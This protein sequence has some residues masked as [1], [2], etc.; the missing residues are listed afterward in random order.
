MPAS[1]APWDR[2]GCRDRADAVP[3]GRQSQ[4]HWKTSA[5][6]F[7]GGPL[8]NLQPRARPEMRQEA[9]HVP[10]ADG[11]TPLRRCIIL[12]RNMKEDRRPAAAFAHAHIPIHHHTDIVKS[13]LTLKRFVTCGEGSGDGSIVAWMIGRV[14]PEHGPPNR[15]KG[16]PRCER[17]LPVTAEI[18]EP[19]RHACNGRGAIPFPLAARSTAAPNRSGNAKVS[20]LQDGT[21][22]RER[23]RSHQNSRDRF[24]LFCCA[25]RS[26]AHE[27]LPCS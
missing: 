6:R 8:E 25:P 10:Q 22:S 9:F 7:P 12:A 27:I 20:Y 16:K 21:A 23:G 2:T 3:I 19:K 14:T 1:Q 24:S 18:G 4:L 26:N 11:Y 13:V 15:H 17:C 5:S